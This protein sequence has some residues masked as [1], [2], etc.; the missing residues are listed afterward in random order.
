MAFQ[1]KFMLVLLL[2]HLLYEWNLSENQYMVTSRGNYENVKKAKN[3]ISELNN[4]FQG[5]LSWF[6]SDKIWVLAPTLSS[7]S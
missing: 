5:V 1:K 6:S 3:E 7:E 2:L 4:Y